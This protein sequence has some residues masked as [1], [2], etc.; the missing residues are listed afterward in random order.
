[1]YK[2][3]SFSFKVLYV[4]FIVMGENNF[5]SLIFLDRGLINIIREWCNFIMVISFCWF[6]FR[7]DIV[8]F[9]KSVVILLGIMMNRDGWNILKC[10]FNNFELYF[11]YVFL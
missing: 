3:G 10:F 9:F 11:V 2:F 5:F 4:W 8:F 6:F 1:M 7:V